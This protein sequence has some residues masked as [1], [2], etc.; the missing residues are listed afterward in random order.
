MH[1][2]IVEE[3]RHGGN[4]KRRRRD[5][6]PFDLLPTKEGMRR[7]HVYRKSFGEHLG[8][9]KR[10]LRS[11]VGQRWNDVYSEACAVIKPN[12]VVRLHIRTHMMDY[13][14]RYTFMRNGEVWFFDRFYEAPVSSLVS[15][16]V[17][18]NFYVHPE[19]G[20]LH[21]AQQW[22]KSREPWPKRKTTRAAVSKWVGKS[23]FLAKLNGLWFACEMRPYSEA[24]ERPPFDLIANNRIA[25]THAY[26]LYERFVYCV[27]KRQL[28]RRELKRHGLANSLEPLGLFDALDP[29]LMRR[30]QGANGN[31]VR[32]RLQGTLCFDAGLYFNFHFRRVDEL[33]YRS[34]RRGRGFESRLRIYA[35]VAQR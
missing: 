15:P 33:G 13:V 9:L 25:D 10:W 16:T 24:P 7:P 26:E 11:K 35:G 19:T 12:D 27:Y 8:P 20:I 28:S 3:P 32:D 29:S 5:A 4:S 22:K 21:E 31:P 2:V 1:K 30:I 14:K 23:L 6:L 17:W 18:P 34:S